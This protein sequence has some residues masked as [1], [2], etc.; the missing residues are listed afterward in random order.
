MRHRTPKWLA[1]VLALSCSDLVGSSEPGDRSATSV[2]VTKPSS[3]ALDAALAKARG[4]DAGRF[5]AAHA[6][7][8]R[9]ALPFDPASAVNF[10]SVQRSPLALDAAELAMFKA[11][12]FVITDKKRF[13]SFTH[14]YEAVYMA[15]LPV[16]VSADSVLHS[17][18]RSYDNLLKG[19]EGRRLAPEL[20][21][22]L[23]S[24]RAA[25]AAGGA[26]SFS[27]EVRADVDLYLAVAERLLTGRDDGPGPAA[28]ADALTIS[29]IVAKARGATGPHRV[30]LFGLKREEDFSQYKPRGHYVVAEGGDSIERERYQGF[31]LDNYFRAMMWLGR[32]DFRLIETLPDGTQTFRRRQLEGALA[33]RSLLS[34]A[35]LAGHQRIDDVVRAFAGEPD[36]MT[37][38][39][40]D[41]L[42]ASLGLGADPARLASLGDEAVVAAVVGGGHGEQKIASHLMVNGTRGST[43][44]LSRSLMFFGQRYVVDSHVFSNVVYDRVGGG[45][46]KRMMPNPLDVAFAALGNDRAASLLAPDLRAHPYAPDLEA[47]RSLVDAHG[48]DFW[49]ANLYNLWLGAIRSLS[50]K[51]A[52]LADPAAA[53]LPAVAATEAW[54]RRLLNTQL[55]SWAELRHDTVL[56]AKQSYTSNVACEFPDAYVDPYPAFYA[57]VEAYAARGHALVKGLPDAKGDDFT[58]A[59]RHYFEHLGG[60]AARLRGMAERQRRREPFDA[61]QMAFINQAVSIHI[62]CGGGNA[63]GW[64]PRLFFGYGKSALEYD[65]TIADVHTQGTDEHGNEVGR[66]LHVGTGMPRA[67]VVAVDTCAGPRAY[68]GLASSYF[69]KITDKYLRLDDATWAQDL[70]DATPPDVP[71]LADLVAR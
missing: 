38:P 5:V 17:L 63:L 48:A 30:R 54:S 26:G 32:I 60:V 33:L 9:D 31:R 61:E 41:G 20:A 24:A 3:A 39:E 27:A 66:V 69:E 13:P 50:P 53:G 55:A 7:P 25:L 62:E 42:V 65:P 46:V 35:A 70:N 49:G 43:L 23:G 15:D 71:W 64:Y 8:S 58:D 14:G 68:V 40:L 47:M 28:G 6:L 1:L 19:L 56:Y 10:A 52:E 34:P 16:Y 44:P 4:L 51:A 11:R 21:S 12:G 36:S 29:D 57:A 2:R 22:L 45:G 18:H 37:L 59:A 67:L